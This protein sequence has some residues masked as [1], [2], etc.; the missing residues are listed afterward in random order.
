MKYNGTTFAKC[1]EIKYDKDVKS[2]SSDIDILFLNISNI[3]SIQMYSDL[4]IV[5]GIS[6]QVYVIRNGIGCTSVISDEL[7]VVFGEHKKK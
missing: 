3:D 5:D 4:I 7:D 6:R 1:R 2:Y